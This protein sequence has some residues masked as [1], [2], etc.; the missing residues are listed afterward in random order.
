MPKVQ[1]SSKGGN[2]TV[3]FQ[4]ERRHLQEARY[5]M[6]WLA[7]YAADKYLSEV[8]AGAGVQLVE[9]LKLLPEPE[10]TAKEPAKTVTK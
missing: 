3:L 9:I 6:E 5:I 1:S 2:T 10:K 4:T 8:C 7:K